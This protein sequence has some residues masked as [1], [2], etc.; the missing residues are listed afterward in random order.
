[1]DDTTFCTDALAELFYKNLLETEDLGRHQAYCEVT[2]RLI[3]RAA[4]I[5]NLARFDDELMGEVP[6]GWSVVGRRRRTIITML[7]EITYMRRIYK[8]TWGNCHHLLDEVL[9]VVPFQHLDHDAFLWIVNRAADVSYEKTARAFN[10]RTGAHITRQTV[11][12][13]VHRCGELLA[14]GAGIGAG[15]PTSAEALFCEFDGFWVNLQSEKKQSAGP[16]RTYREQFRKKSMEMKVWVAY[17][18][19]DKGD[20]NRRIAAF[21]WASDSAPEEFFAECA[22]R[23][24]AVYDIS[25]VD[26][27]ITASDAAG[28]CKTHGLDAF[29]REDAVVI[30][31]L[32]TWHINQKVYRAFSSEDDRSE[33]LRYLYSK[34]FDGFFVALDARMDKEPEDERA[35]R[36]TELYD[37]IA[38]NLDWLSGS[39]LSMRIREM[40]SEDMTRVFSDR[41][42]R[43][44]L[45]E[46]LYKRRYERL[47][48]ELCH[49]ADTCTE[50]R[51]LTYLGFLK[52][53]EEA[54]RLIKTYGPVSL[55]TMEGTNSKVYAA[56]LKVW[57]CAWSRRG[58]ISMMRI[59]A[60]LASGLKLKAPGYDANLTDKEMSRIEAWRRR[61]F[62]VSQSTGAGYEPP[63]G[64]V[65]IDTRMAP[66]MY[67]VLAS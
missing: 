1:M 15:P 53:A 51:R 60:A 41:T 32:D 17:A 39:S 62:P 61:S 29:A 11:M 33:Y 66:A 3:I 63:Q 57:G 6:K 59:R 49:I 36:R 64:S 35:Q 67:A 38:N 20:D 21:H 65:V 25:H 47:S 26:W 58:A 48:E 45:E 52:D 13:C 22:Q 14:S 37:Y 40:L 23:T 31:R 43:Q 34:D 54:I 44:H 10:D 50:S 2:A 56:R 28:W 46:L 19:K 8:D 4:F 18:S 16:R 24:G 55:G 7:G 12:R 30:S 42:F 9:G 5:K 27:L